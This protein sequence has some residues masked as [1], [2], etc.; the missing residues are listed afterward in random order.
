MN[1]RVQEVLDGLKRPLS[2]YSYA[3]VV[4]PRVYMVLDHMDGGPSEKVAIEP[5][6]D[7][8]IDLAT[9]INIVIGTIGRLKEA[10]RG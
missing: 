6:E 3:H 4:G 5:T 10:R 9:G 7:A 2:H 8:A 1:D